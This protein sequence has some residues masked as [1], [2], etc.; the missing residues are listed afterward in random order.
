MKATD[1]SGFLGRLRSLEHGLAIN[2]T[3]EFDKEGVPGYAPP[4]R[5]IW[6]VLCE[7]VISLGIW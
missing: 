2:L 4:F 7:L 3:M 5:D 1:K 6:A